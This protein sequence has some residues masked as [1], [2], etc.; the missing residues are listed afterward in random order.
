M[1]KMKLSSTYESELKKSE[2]KG[3]K[4]GYM[5]A[6]E[7]KNE[8]IDYLTNSFNA[9]DSIRLDTKKKLGKALQEIEEHKRHIK[10]QR[11]EIDGLNLILFNTN[12]ILDNY[13]DGEIECLF[14]IM[15]KCKKARVKTKYR[16]KILKLVSKRLMERG[17]EINE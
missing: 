3:Y 14:A 9:S 7:F 1:I 12:N 16:N 8:Q 2:N 6:C 13:K 5:E 17:F 4:K 15:K 10:H 11:D